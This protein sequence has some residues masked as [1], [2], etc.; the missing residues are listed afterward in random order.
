MSG[1]AQMKVSF[2]DADTENGSWYSRTFR[3]HGLPW[4]FALEE[5]VEGVQDDVHEVVFESMLCEV[6]LSTDV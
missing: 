1:I 5:R 3:R 4:K 6:D 2:G